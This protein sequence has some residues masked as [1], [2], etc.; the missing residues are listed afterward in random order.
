M[1]SAVILGHVRPG[2]LKFL[3]AEL[4]TF[5]QL[6]P[7]AQ[8][9]FGRKLAS[10]IAA[11]QCDRKQYEKVRNQICLADVRASVGLAPEKSLKLINAEYV[12]IL[13]E[14][15]IKITT[16]KLEALDSRFGINTPSV[17]VLIPTQ[18]AT[19]RARTLLENG[20]CIF[21]MSSDGKWA[22]YAIIEG[23]LCK[24]ELKATDHYYDAR[25]LNQIKDVISAQH[26]GPHFN[27]THFGR[28]SCSCRPRV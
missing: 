15:G 18:E 5:N 12:P 14:V 8:T 6:K 1:F 3:D 26:K 13:E 9:K 24:S 27:A 11:E 28:R 20:Q 23:Q 19:E 16:P 2:N 25:A 10:L 21:G 7:E 4:E 17:R 22:A